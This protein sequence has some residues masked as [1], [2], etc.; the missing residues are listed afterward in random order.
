LAGR[1][2][3]TNDVPDAGPY[4]GYPLQPLKEAMKTA[5][6]LGQ[7]NEIR[8]NLKR[9]MRHLQLSDASSKTTSDL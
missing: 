2:A 6:S 7:L 4:G 1:S 9:V 5:V 8:R 3:V